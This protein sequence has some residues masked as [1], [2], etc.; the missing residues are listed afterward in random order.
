[1]FVY[2]AEVKKLEHDLGKSRDDILDRVERI[3]RKAIENI[4]DHA[5]DLVRGYAHLPHLPRAFTHD[6]DRSSREVSAVTGGDWERLQGRLDVFIE[7]GSPT[8]NGIPHWLPAS[9]RYGPQWEHDVEEAAERA[10]F[11]D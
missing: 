5:A 6:V 9:D 3:T 8:S 2:D 4:E 7:Y 11:G 10:V 1:M